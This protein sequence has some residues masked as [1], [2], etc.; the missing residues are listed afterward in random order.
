MKIIV[1][2]TINQPTDALLKYSEL[3]DWQLIVVGDLK[4]PHE[5]YG[6][7]N[8]IYLTPEYQSDTYSKL[9]TSI[10]WNSIQRRNIGF[11]EAW[12]RGGEIIATVDDDNI[13]YENW[14][15]DLF[16]GQSVVAD[17]FRP[18]KC[19]FFDPLAV[20]E[21]KHLWH[22]GFPIELVKDREVEYFGRERIN[23]KVQANLW[24]GDPDVD[25]IARLA[26]RPAV[27]FQPR[28]YFS[29]QGLCP[30]NSQNTFLARDVLPY[31]AC[32]P[33]VGRM[34]DIWGAYLMQLRFPNSVLF[35]P[36]TVFQLRN[37]QD[38]TRNLQDELLG[39]K[40]TLKLLKDLANY[41]N[42]LPEKTLEFIEHYQEQYFA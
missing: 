42:F 34:D 36:S 6:D 26:H 39:Y 40:M 27:K 29:G 5:M 2:T 30:F 22:R 3:G 4:T 28:P 25:A 9:S 12:R 14:G 38:L 35:G 23:V 11:V 24:D 15:K 21:Y 7:I 19:D 18:T 33:H 32:L 10:G 20:T 16:I 37:P 31:Y 13:P 17:L 8:C 1:T 41:R